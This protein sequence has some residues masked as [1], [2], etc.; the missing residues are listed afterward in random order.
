MGALTGV[1]PLDG[2]AGVAVRGGVGEDAGVAGLHPDVEELHHRRATGWGL[3][4]RRQRRR[5]SRIRRRI[6]YPAGLGLTS[7]WDGSQL[8]RRLLHLAGEEMGG[9][10]PVPR[11][12]GRRR[13]VATNAV[14]CGGAGEA[15]NAA[16]EAMRCAA[17]GQA[18]RRV[19][20]VGRTRGRA[21]R[22]EERRCDVEGG[23]VEG[24]PTPRG[25]AG[26]EQRRGRRD[27]RRRGGGGLGATGG[28]GGGGD[29]HTVMRDGATGGRVPRL[30][31][32]GGWGAGTGGRQW[33]GEERGVGGRDAQ[34]AAGCAGV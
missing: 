10:V 3:E 8:P 22:L 20:R 29:G 1:V 16:D 26:E 27:D 15:C 23:C 19:R 4:L 11:H 6:S 34:L 9:M 21:R 28:R 25:A 31:S 17:G 30:K 18:G 24:P 14:W 7:T 33:T 5:S 2:V 13:C 12:R 32:R